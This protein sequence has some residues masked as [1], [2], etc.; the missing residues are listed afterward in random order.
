MTFSKLADYFFSSQKRELYA[1]SGLFYLFSNAAF[2][3]LVSRY[4]EFVFPFETILAKIYVPVTLIG[5]TFLFF[6]AFYL[7]THQRVVL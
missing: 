4:L 1:W 6:V 7:L 3:V 5:Q 2:I